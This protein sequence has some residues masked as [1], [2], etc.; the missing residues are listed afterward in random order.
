MDDQ[1]RIITL[2]GLET[3]QNCFLLDILTL[4]FSQS[5]SKSMFFFIQKPDQNLFML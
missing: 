5:L 3:K 2:Q 1:Q 4:T